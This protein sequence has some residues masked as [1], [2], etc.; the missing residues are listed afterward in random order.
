VKRKRERALGR[1]MDAWTPPGR[2]VEKGTQASVF[3]FQD[4]CFPT[5]PKCDL[6]GFAEITC[7]DK[8]G[9]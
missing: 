8:R 3:Q 4:L 5:D 1:W 7:G 2:V 6:G 9:E